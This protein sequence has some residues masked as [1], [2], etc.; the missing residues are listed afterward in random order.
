MGQSSTLPLSFRLW[1]QRKQPETRKKIW[2]PLPGPQKVAYHSDADEL[3]YGRSAGGGKSDL[4]IGLS[5]TAHKKSIIF[6]REYRNT[7]FEPISATTGMVG[8]SVRQE[9]LVNLLC[10]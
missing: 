2:T 5:L 8:M 6:R 3:F 7:P 9:D 10:S 4:I 1:K